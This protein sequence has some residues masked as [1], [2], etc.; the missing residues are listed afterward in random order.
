LVDVIERLIGK[1]YDLK[2]Y[3]SNV[4]LARLTGANRD[5]IFKVIPHIERLMVE[6]IEDVLAHG[7]VIVIGNS[8]PEFSDIAKQLRSDQR[9]VDFVRIRRIEEEHRNYDGICW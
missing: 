7:E 5:Y 3:D 2:L 9:V 8:A 4:N 6:R 1:G